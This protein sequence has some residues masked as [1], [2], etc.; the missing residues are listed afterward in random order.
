M[1]FPQDAKGRRA[2]DAR[3]Q[4]ESRLEQE[5]NDESGRKSSGMGI[6][7]LSPQSPKYPEK[8]NNIRREGDNSSSKA[9]DRFGA[10]MYNISPIEVYIE[11]RSVA[12]TNAF[13]S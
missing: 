9:G 12:N 5:R 3:G 7:S 2:Q 8:N 6:D 13:K 1:R 10:S 11:N 4:S